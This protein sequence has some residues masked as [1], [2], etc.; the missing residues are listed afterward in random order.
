MALPRFHVGPEELK[1]NELRIPDRELGHLA[2]RRIKTGD[3]L[4]L[5]DARGAEAV[6]RVEERR[7]N[8]VLVKIVDRPGP[9]ASP[10][11]ETVLGL[12]ICRWERLRLA[13]EKAAELGASAV[14]PLI[15]RFSQPVRPDLEIKLE[16]VIIEALKQCRRSYG[17]SLGPPQE[18]T[19]FLKDR[20]SDGL[21]IVLD[22]SGPPLAGLLAG[23]QGPVTILAGPEG[24]L[25]PQELGRAQEAGFLLAG[26]SPAFL[27]TE[28]A[29]L[30]G[31]TLVMSLMSRAEEAGGG[32]EPA[33]RRS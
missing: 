25:S 1:G 17:P 4:S 27:R 23:R 15:T 12:G 18:L 28:T 20:P 2:A 22:R 9:L 10:G 14:R 3:L 30:A 16:R 6:A 7:Q 11:P 26:L 33:G 24:G 21:K 19:R 8:R 29:V 32:S 13:V 5:F 31:L